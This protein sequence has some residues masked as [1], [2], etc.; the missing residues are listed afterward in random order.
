LRVF[1]GL[2]LYFKRIVGSRQFAVVS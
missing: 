1:L 2:R